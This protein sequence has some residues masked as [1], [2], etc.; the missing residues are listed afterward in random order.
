M[1]IT[2][3]GLG[4]A[5][6][7]GVEGFQSQREDN[8][9]QRT[10][11]Q[12]KTDFEQAQ[13]AKKA[14]G[15]APG[16]FEEVFQVA[17]AMR[18]DFDKRWS[19]G[20][21]ISEL[22]QAGNFGAPPPGAGPGAV[23]VA[24]PP[25]IPTAPPPGP[26]ITGGIGAAP[27]VPAPVPPPVIAPPVPPQV[28]GVAPGFAHGGVAQVPDDAA[29]P[30]IPPQA[31]PPQAVPPQA[32]PPQAIPPQQAAPPQQ[33]PPQPGPPAPQPV[34]GPPAPE[35]VPTQPSPPAYKTRRDEYQD[36]FKKTS[37][38]VALS[39]GLEGLQMFRD[40]EDALSRKQMF[41]YGMDGV[42]AMRDGN[43]GEAVR[44]LNTMLNVSPADPGMR[45]EAYDGNVHL[46]GNDGKRGKPY[47]QQ[48]V[49]ALIE[50]NLKTPENYLDFQAEARAQGVADES[51]RSSKETE[52]LARRAQTEV[53]R[54]AQEDERLG[55]RTQTEVERG[56][57]VTEEETMKHNVEME[58]VYSTNADS[59]QRAV[60][61]VEKKMPSDIALTGATIIKALKDAD[62]NS[63]R[64][65]SLAKAKALGWSEADF[66]AINST[67]PTM[68][69]NAKLDLGMDW[70]GPMMDDPAMGILLQGGIIDIMTSNPP[71][72]GGANYADSIGI[73]ALAYSGLA[74]VDLPA[75]TVIPRVRQLPTGEW[76][77]DYAGKVIKVPGHVALAIKASK[78]LAQ[79]KK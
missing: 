8:R 14:I 50:N 26:Q 18:A 55:R 65:A 1:G 53:E 57:L 61:V 45:F 13:A 66:L 71:E 35:A 10:S 52:Q 46:V 42:T 47:N 36:W 70:M 2:L 79:G 16:A 29:I 68:I 6:A 37:A 56:A 63:V 49:M 41:G 31:V 3:Q 34:V 15:T 22:A 51:V 75:G 11:D 48:Q 73:G 78:E 9:Q 59:R 62:S 21:G 19:S 28:A 38:A 43:T 39:G 67:L 33:A 76:E 7:G 44:Q 32:V 20:A 54:G 12:K 23:P 27:V 5:A 64:A 30:A 72:P 4:A 60:T 74:G 24:P 25:A 77:V 69:Q 17:N 58:T 40:H